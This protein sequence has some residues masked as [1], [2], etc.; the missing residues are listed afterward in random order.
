M[1][2]NDTGKYELSPCLNILQIIYSSQPLPDLFLKLQFEE[3]NTFMIP[4]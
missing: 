1:L 2:M 3:V 4:F